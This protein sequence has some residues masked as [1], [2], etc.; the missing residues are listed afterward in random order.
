MTDPDAEKAG[1][2]TQAMLKMSKFDIQA[3]LE[4]HGQ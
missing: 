1:K 3:L 2:V 4:A